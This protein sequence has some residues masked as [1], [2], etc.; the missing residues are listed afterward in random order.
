MT[1]VAAPLDASALARAEQNRLALR[2][3]G[4]LLLRDLEVVRKTIPF[5]LLRTVTQPLLFVFVFAYVFPKIGQGVGGSGAGA[6]AFSTLLAPGMVAAAII[7]QGIQSVALPLVQEFGYTREIEDRVMAPLPVWAIG[8]AKICSGALQSAI[9]AV[10]VVPFVLTIPVSSVN[11]DINWIEL[12][13]VG[14]LACMLGGSLGL[15]VGTRV[16]PRQVPLIFSVL[17]IPMTMLGAVYYPWE[18]LSPIAW[19]K[20]AVLINPLLY[21][22][23]GLRMALTSFP[24]MTTWAIYGALAAFTAFLMWLGLGGFKKRVL[25]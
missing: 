20:W 10:I 23:E 22:S 17:V 8:L 13:T 5:F 24:H 4:A 14:A 18:H 3:F 19:L 9:A 16:E 7:F 11:L 6:S 21:M 2:S 12:V 1:T 15:A 25:T